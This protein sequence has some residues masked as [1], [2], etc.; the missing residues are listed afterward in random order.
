MRKASIRLNHVEFETKVEHLRSLAKTSLHPNIELRASEQRLC[1]EGF[2]LLLASYWEELINNDFVDALNRDTSNYASQVELVLPKNLPRDIC[3]GLL[4]GHG[5]LNFR[6]VGDLL[7]KSR[8]LI[9]PANNPFRQI[10]APRRKSIDC[11]INVRNYLAH[12]SKKAH[13]EYA[14]VLTR[15]YSYT[16]VVSPGQFLRAQHGQERLPRLFHFLDIFTRTSVKM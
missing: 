4:V 8:Q 5:Y 2:T 1:L 6:S 10:S 12:R 15:E 16:R 9:V 14:R 11:F 7:G 13:R 3:F